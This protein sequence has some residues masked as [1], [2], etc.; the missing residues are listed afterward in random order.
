MQMLTDW[1]LAIMCPM[2]RKVDTEDIS[3]YPPVSLTY[4]MCKMFEGK[5]KKALHSYL[6]DT[7]AIW[8][9][10][11]AF[12]PHRC[13]PSNVMV[14]VG[15]LTRMMD[16]RLAVYIILQFPNAFSLPSYNTFSLCWSASCSVYVVLLGP[17]WPT[18]Y[19]Y[20]LL[21]KCLLTT[22]PHK[23]VVLSLLP[24]LIPYP[25]QLINI[26]TYT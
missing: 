19:H 12:L 22:H 2:P 6:N 23:S 16:D 15:T 9:H 17:F 21:K 8:P 4:L 24:T 5:L 10:Y 11:H 14:F 13:C 7:R 25:L 3:N 18:F 1:R 26:S 20:K